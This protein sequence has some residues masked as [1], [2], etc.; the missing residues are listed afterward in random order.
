VSA[1]GI[2]QL[3]RALG[4]ANQGPTLLNLYTNAGQYGWARILSLGGTATWESWTA[5][6]DGNSESHGWGAV[7]LD[8]YVRYLLGVK[9]L[10]AQFAQAQIMPLDFG[11]LLPYVSGSL[12]TD[13]G[14]LAVEWD[15]SA[16]LYHLALTI[17]DNVTAAVYVP[18]AGLAD[19]IVNVDGT[20]V[21]GTLTNLCGTTNAYLGVPGIGSGTHNFQR[22]LI[23]PLAAFSGAPANLFATQQVTFTDASIGSITNWLWN[24][25]DGTMVTNNS[26][27]NVTHA[28]AS[29]GSYTVSLTVAGAG[30]SNTST[31][32][33]CITASPKPVLGLAALTGGKLVFSGSNGPAGMQYRIL[34]ATNV[35]MPLGTWVPLVTNWFG[36]DGSYSYTNMRGVNP[37]GYFLLIS[38]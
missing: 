2:L 1:L 11:N 7:G 29:A 21:T 10:K 32:T 5:N 16:T 20:N 19:L 14:N 31:Q 22:A 6:T 8:G 3:E 24:F 25:G 33:A 27:A 23:F 34:M 9:P 28:Y 15:R 4:E 38:P 12:L 30:G 37:A 18:Q 35:T 13:R 17:P 36:L 26:N